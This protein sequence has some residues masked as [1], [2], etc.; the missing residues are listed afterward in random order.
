MAVAYQEGD[1]VQI[2]AR[3]DLESERKAGTYFAHF[4]GLVGKLQKVYDTGD[5]VLEIEHDCLGEDV[6]ARHIDIQ[7]QMRTKWYDGLSEEGRNR[8]TDSEKDF[9]LRYTVLV[10]QKDLVVVGTAALIEADVPEE[11]VEE[12]TPARPSSADL[13]AAEDAYLEARQTS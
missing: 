1:R 4:G 9:K 8:L 5:A 3:K 2:I 13:E 10:Q 11:I 12:E 7:E 6:L